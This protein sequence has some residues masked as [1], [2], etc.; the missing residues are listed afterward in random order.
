MDQVLFRPVEVRAEDQCRRAGRGQ[1]R[2][3]ELDPELSLPYRPYHRHQRRRY[4]APD[5]IVR[6]EV[7]ILPT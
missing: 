4:L 2:C 1:S 3:G 6:V 5:E 7:E